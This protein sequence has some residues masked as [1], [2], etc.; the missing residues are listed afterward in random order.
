LVAAVFLLLGA[1][2]LG[3]FVEDAELNRTW[4]TLEASPGARE[5]FSEDIVTGLPDPAR[6][7][8]L[9]AIKPGTPLATKLSWRWSG[10]MRPGEQS[11]WVALTSEQVN[12]R[13]RGFAW[14]GRVEAGPLNLLTAADYYVEGAGRMRLSL[15]GLVTVGEAS[16]P[17]YFKGAVGR[18]V[19]E[20]VF[21]PTILLPGPNVRIEGVDDSRF[22]VTLE[23]QGESAFLTLRVDQEGRVV[24]SVV[25]RWGN[26]TDDGS[27]RYI[28]YGGPVEAEGTFGG[29]TIPTRAKAGWWYGTDQYLEVIHL[30]VESARYE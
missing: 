2:I 28:P 20:G 9:H 29:Y 14:K 27:Y 1:S 8:F 4:E 5:K 19:A 21:F 23:M 30:T 7:Y 16:G 22:T 13:N 10:E 17:D 18:V 25:Q 3:R 11:P 6:R 15:V 26:L 12:V 24:E